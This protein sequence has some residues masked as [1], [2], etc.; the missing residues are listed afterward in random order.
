[1]ADNPQR[2]DH[3]LVGR[4]LMATRSKA[5]E[6]IVHGMVALNGTV[7]TNPSTTVLE[8]DEINLLEPQR[9]VSRGGEKLEAALQAFSVQ[10]EGKR[11]LDAGAS[12]GG[13][14]QC[15]LAHGAAHVTAV[16]VGTAQLHPSLRDHPRL[17]SLEQTDIRTLERRAFPDGFDLITADLSFISLRT[18][19]V[20]LVDL[21]AEQCTLIALVKPQFEVGPQAVKKGGIVKDATH[22]RQAVQTVQAILEQQ[23]EWKVLGAIPSPLTGGD[24]N[25][26]YLLCAQKSVVP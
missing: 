12:T 11:C 16:D 19:L 15:L 21:A 3:A 6:W 2:L 22:H 23:S 20:G 8:H 25:Q 13:F 1:M 17:L 18:V 9:Y 10:V 7:C 14:S 4:R 5:R 24:G 26:E